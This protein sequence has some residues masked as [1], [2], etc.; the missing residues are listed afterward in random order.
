MAGGGS[1]SPLEG[2]EEKEG[3]EE[4]EGERQERFDN[5]LFLLFWPKK[6]CVL[7]DRVVFCFATI[8]FFDTENSLFLQH[9]LCQY[10]RNIKCPEICVHSHDFHRRIPILIVMLVAASLIMSLIVLIDNS[11]ID[12][13]NR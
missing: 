7:R 10:Y 2:M 11:M 5:V 6:T 9:K 3:M 1:P 13:I 12:C 4:E 8:F